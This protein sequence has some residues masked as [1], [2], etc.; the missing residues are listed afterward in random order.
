MRRLRLKRGHQD[1]F[2][3][4]RCVTSDGPYAGKRV[5]DLVVLAVVALP[6]LTLGAVCALAVA[7]TSKGPVFF[8]QDRIGMDGEPFTVWKFRTMA[9]G[10]NPIFPDATRITRVGAVLRRFSLDELPQLI[11]VATG[12]MSIVGPRPTL[13]YQ[14]ERYDDHQRRRLAV[15]P[16]LTGLA[17]VSGRNSLT[18]AE[19][20]AYDVK[21]V[22]TQSPLVDLGLIARTFTTMLSGKGVEGHPE[23]DPIASTVAQQEPGDSDEGTARR[24]AVEHTD[25]DAP[26]GGRS[27]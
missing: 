14:V 9:H 8:R 15:R 19:R 7:V 10:D 1:L 22:E 4:A 23:D 6:A 16:G 5:V 21:Y 27:P 24:S 20:I 11:N 3:Y 25:S 26:T 13:A 18:W 2:R 12:D 17:Q